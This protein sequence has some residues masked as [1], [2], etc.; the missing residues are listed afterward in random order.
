M[1]PTRDRRRFTRFD[2]AVLML[3]TA[4]GLV[5]TKSLLDIYHEFEVSFSEYHTS[6]I[7]RWRSAT[8]PLVVLWCLTL[9]VLRP[10]GTPARRVMRGPGTMTGV[11]VA[12]FAARSL[13]EWTVGL[14][15]NGWWHWESRWG[16][17]MLVSMTSHLP[18]MK[19]LVG[20]V[21]AATWL[22]LRL[23]RWWRPEPD[24]IDRA[25]RVLGGYWVAMFLVELYRRL[26]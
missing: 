21:V 1:A 20:F 4:L 2:A 6:A 25:G 24:W 26:D 18:S 11:V 13:V 5:I 8:V 3:V 12:L 14:L 15:R 10:R 17:D 22:G 16:F 19:E 9:L 7:D 23:G